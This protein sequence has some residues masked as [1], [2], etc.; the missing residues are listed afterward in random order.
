MTS[1]RAAVRA[2]RL[3]SNLEVFS[4]GLAAIGNF[5]VFDRL[6]LVERGKTCLLD[7]LDMNKYVL[8]ARGGLNE[9]KTLGCV[10]PLHSTFSHHVVSAGAKKQ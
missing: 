5:F 4:R 9:S 2:A 7:R 3:A 8:A 10:E 6:P 1:G